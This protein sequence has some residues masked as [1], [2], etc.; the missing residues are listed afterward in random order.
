[1]KPE[2]RDLPPAA[3]HRKGIAAACIAAA[4]GAIF[5][6]VLVHSLPHNPVGGVF[7][8]R[9]G[10]RIFIPEGW[11]FFTKNPRDRQ[12]QVFAERDG[13]WIPAMR[14]PVARPGN[15]FGV[16]RA[17]RAQGVE[18]GMILQKVPDAAWA[19]CAS[20]DGACLGAAS[21]D[22]EILNGLAA[23]TLCGRIG[24]VLREPV[25][26]AWRSS[27]DEIHMPALAARLRVRCS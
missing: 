16:D 8:D 22:F 4:W 18:L 5:L 2:S 27:R 19:E 9:I 7:P 1:M 14:M 26:W 3:D 20:D 12:F 24:V 15:L 23:P 17:A 10:I 6:F 21:G 11:A 25:P 13:L